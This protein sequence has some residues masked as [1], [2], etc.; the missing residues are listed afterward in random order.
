MLTG[1]SQDLEE[2]SLV[3][4]LIRGVEEVLAGKNDNDISYEYFDGTCKAHP[5]CK[6]DPGRM[7]VYQEKNVKRMSL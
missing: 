1:H 5:Y 2:A 3:E 7:V 4:K 6:E